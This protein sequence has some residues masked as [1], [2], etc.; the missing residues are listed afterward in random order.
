MTAQVALIIVGCVFSVL[1]TFAIFYMK[2][3][4]T[5]LQRYNDIQD[6][7]IERLEQKADAMHRFRV[8][9]SGRR[10]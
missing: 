5:G 6:R 2:E 1:L 9:R 7:R 10:R 4:R 8:P 3:I